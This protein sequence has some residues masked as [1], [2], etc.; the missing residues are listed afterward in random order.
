MPYCKMVDLLSIFLIL[1]ADDTVLFTTDMRS[2]QQRIDSIYQYS[3]WW[4]L[5]TRK[6][7]EARNASQMPIVYKRQIL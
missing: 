4:S 5:K 1:F 3:K 6:S 7:M 2:L